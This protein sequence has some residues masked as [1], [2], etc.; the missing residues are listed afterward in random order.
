MPQAYFVEIACESCSAWF[1]PPDFIGDDPSFIPA[2]LIGIHADC[3]FCGWITE[4]SEDDL[5]IQAKHDGFPGIETY[6]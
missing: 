6:H 4:C 3:P 5:R 2:W 1:P